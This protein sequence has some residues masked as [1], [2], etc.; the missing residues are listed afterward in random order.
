VIVELRWHDVPH[1]LYGWYLFGTE[2]PVNGI[3]VSDDDS[4]DDDDLLAEAAEMLPHGEHV[5]TYVAGAP[6]FAMQSMWA[7]PIRRYRVTVRD[8][9]VHTVVEVDALDR[10][11]GVDTTSPDT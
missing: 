4:I 10:A 9:V 3:A 1:R 2:L 5:M 7:A 8:R 6:Q 11:I